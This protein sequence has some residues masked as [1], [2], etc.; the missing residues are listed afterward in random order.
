MIY[1]LGRWQ[2]YIHRDRMGYV[3]MTLFQ[4]LEMDDLDIN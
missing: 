1:A 3:M 2:V 4:K